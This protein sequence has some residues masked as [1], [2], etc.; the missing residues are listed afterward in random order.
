MTPTKAMRGVLRI[1]LLFLALSGTAGL[2]VYWITFR[3][4]QADWR[5]LAVGLLLAAVLGWWPWIS[6]G[7]AASL[8]L[9]T[10]FMGPEPQLRWQ[11]AGEILVFWILGLGWGSLAKIQLHPQA[12]LSAPRRAP[13]SGGATPSMR[14]AREEVFGPVASVVAVKDY[15]EL[16][17]ADQDFR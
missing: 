10:V 6:L 7:V 15:E 8:C 4:P 16:F 13:V 5:I 1:L 2:V 11:I 14:S 12:N 3:T 9:L 17:G